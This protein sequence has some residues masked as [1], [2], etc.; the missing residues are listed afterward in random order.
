MQWKA[1]TAEIYFEVLQPQP[2]QPQP[3]LI[4][5]EVFVINFIIEK[6]KVLKAFSVKMILESPSL[7]LC[8]IISV[9]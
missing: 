9:L 5:N 6:K 4:A 2:H 8:S 1:N 7:Y 3:Q